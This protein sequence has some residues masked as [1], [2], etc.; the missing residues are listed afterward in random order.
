[1]SRIRGFLWRLVREWVPVI[2]AV[3]VIRA[4]VVESFLVPTGSMLNTI[5]IGDAMLVN[6]FVY[7]IKLP[8]SDRVVIPVSSPR[9]GDIIVFRFPADPDEPKDPANPHRYQRIF[10]RWLQLLP[11]FWD[12]QRSFFVWY[13][14]QNYVKRC[15]AIALDTVEYRD[16]RLYVNGQLQTEPYVI[17]SDRMVFPG[18]ESVAQFNP[19]LRRYVGNFQSEWENRRFFRNR[20]LSP[21]VRDNF[22]PVVIPPGHCMAMGDNRDNSEDSRFWGPLD[23]RYVKGRPM[24]IYFSSSAAS[25]PP[26]LLK[27][28]LSPWA[29]RVQRIGRLVR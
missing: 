7:G 6:K 25:N 20:E 11:L 2:A 22:G 26:N 21:F 18:L 8:F 29:I 4:F 5:Y 15:V 16:K 23:L 13:T 28:L 3:L 12:R 10:P 14:P 17:H 1:M 24:V 19:D 9:R 27:I